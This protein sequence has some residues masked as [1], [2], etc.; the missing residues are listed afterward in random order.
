MNK[1]AS[2]EKSIDEILAESAPEDYDG[3][4]DFK[5]LSP[6]ERLDWL[7]ELAEFIHAFKGRARTQGEPME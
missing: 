3:H 5:T 2:S 7:F 1:S 4:T 6:E